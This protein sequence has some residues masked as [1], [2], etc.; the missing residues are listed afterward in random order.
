NKSVFGRKDKLGFP[1][2]L[3]STIA[4][5]IHY[6]PDLLEYAEFSS[7][8]NPKATHK[9]FNAV[10]F[11]NFIAK[12]E[13]DNKLCM[14]VIPVMET[15]KSMKFHYSIDLANIKKHIQHKLSKRKP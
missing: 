5:A 12:I 15:K 9:K 6:L 1:L 11:W 14:L 13:I 4:T 8:G 2:F 7:F 10:R 3:N